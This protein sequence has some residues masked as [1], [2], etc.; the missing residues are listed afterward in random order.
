MFSNLK[1]ILWTDS[2]KVKIKKSLLLSVI[3]IGDL[4][5]LKDHVFLKIH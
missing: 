2:K 1:I 4:K 3:R 5:T